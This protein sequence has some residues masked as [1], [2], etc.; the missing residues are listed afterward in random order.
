MSE[1]ER[2]LIEQA[3][4]RLATIS[5]QDDADAIAKAIEVVD[6]STQDFAAKRMDNS[7]RLALT[8]QSV[9]SI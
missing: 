8:G 4:A 3:M 5:R 7:I 2:S 9:D 1:D 6:A